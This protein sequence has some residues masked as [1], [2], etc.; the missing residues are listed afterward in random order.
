MN[1]FVEECRR[2]WRRL[3]VPDSVADEMA[4]D[5][6]ADLEEADADG[7]SAEEVLGSDAFDPRSFAAAW[8]AERGVIQQPSPSAHGLPR[9]FL[10]TAGIGAFALIA[11]LG[12]VLVIVDSPSTRGRLALEPAQVRPAMRTIPRT[13]R[14][15]VTPPLPAPDARFFAAPDARIVTDMNDSGIDTRGVGSVLLIV[16]LAG[17]V[18]LALFSLWFADRPRAR[19]LTGA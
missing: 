19:V 12:A 11:I 7:A 17:V 6:E 18:P 10:M 1:E 8:A 2:E 16:G 9:R 15:V 13:V 3:Q 14:V 5:L 4:A